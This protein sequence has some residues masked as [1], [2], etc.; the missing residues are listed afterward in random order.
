MAGNIAA[1]PRTPDC[2]AGWNGYQSENTTAKRRVWRLNV[3][4]HVEVTKATDRAKAAPTTQDVHDVHLQPLAIFAFL[5]WLGITVNSL[6]D[7]IKTLYGY[8]IYMD[9]YNQY[10][11][12]QLE[13]TNTFNNVSS[14]VCSLNGP[15]LDCYF[16]LPVYGTGSLSGATCRSYY[17]IDKA[18]TQHIGNFFGNCT[19][20]S[21]ERIEIPD[22]ARFASTQWSVQTS[23][24]DRTCLEMLGE[25][26]SFA[27][28]T[29]TTAN[30][31]VINHR[32]SQTETTK[33]CKEFGGYYILNRTSGI[34]EVLVANTSGPF[35]FTSIALTYLP[36]VLS[37]EP[38][39]KCAIDL[40]VGGTATH[41]TTSAWYGDTTAPWTAR[42][43]RTADANDVTSTTD[44]KVLVT[45][46][47]Y[48]EGDLTQIRLGY[49]DAYRLT[50]LAVITYYRVTSIYYPIALVYWRQRTPLFRWLRQ[51]HMGLV[52]HKRERHN[53]FV[54][55]LLSAEAVASTEDVV[56]YCQQVI[57]SGP[58][59]F[60]LALKY[61]SI[62][63]IIWPCA[64]LLLLT[65]RLLQIL[66][67]RQHAFAMTEDLFF[68][69]AP[70][71]WLYIPVQVTSQGMSLFQGYRWTGAIVHH[72]TNSISNVYAKQ[73]SCLTLYMQL[74]G[75]F[76]ILSPFTTIFIDAVWRKVTNSSSIFVFV[77]SPLKHRLS[78]RVLDITATE[79]RVHTILMLST[80]RTPREIALQMTRAK[81][82]PSR[83][84]ESL[85]LAAEGFVCLVYGKVH[86]MGITEW[87]VSSPIVNEL[88]HVAVIDQGNR[89]AF[90][91][92]VSIE[93]LARITSRPACL[94]IPDIY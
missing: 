38:L 40:H 7:P 67:G 83:L 57:Y 33:W 79:S 77:L 55:L 80:R 42:T 89:V 59:L 71:V 41:I 5:A 73:L 54:L 1:F 63:R 45:T 17:P 13:V 47:H 2:Y 14:R 69:G 66:F 11:V 60:L 74:F 8:Y 90:D 37:L 56:M 21:G 24:L 10:V 36:P 93:S 52:L 26:D 25:G 32:V 23:S 70:V 28:D 29:I 6:L 50:L 35:A 20:P 58:S 3:T 75:Y 12:W 39:L 72:Y 84:C 92:A 16:E 44:G 62:T 64:C 30:G 9:S 68:L 81:L 87:G 31:R 49:K 46:K 15:F 22:P 18:P 53:L 43:T 91:A 51:R 48:S 34:Q 4:M 65:S 86:A 88:G 27:C 85:N 61:M 82:P 78:R 94:G 19:L 76:T